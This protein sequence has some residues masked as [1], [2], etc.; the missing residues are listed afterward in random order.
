MMRRGW[1]WLK[2]LAAPGSLRYQLL[3]RSLGIMAVLLLCIGVSQY[4]FMKS[5]LFNN[6]AET[7]QVQ[8]NSVPRD[9]LGIDQPE[10]R[11]R[12][13]PGILR[14]NLG[15]PGDL[16]R[17]PGGGAMGNNGKGTQAPDTPPS[18]TGQSITDSSASEGTAGDERGRKPYFF[19]ADSSLAIVDENGNVT[20]IA[21]D[22]GQP[23]PVISKEKYASIMAELSAKT[24]TKTKYLVV[25]GAEGTGEQLVV[26]R[27]MGMP[28]RPGGGLIQ[29]ST[30]TA[31]L[32]DTLWQQ[33]MI[34]VVL[35]ALA[36]CVGIGL[37]LPVLRRTLVP[38]SRIVSAVQQTDAGN[39]N[40]R[41]PV[42]QG[43]E[44]I[45]R[46]SDSFN[47]MLE[48]L[49]DSFQ[50]EREA[51]E[52]MRRFI[53]DASHELRTPLTSIHG[54]LEVLLR[55]A[56]NRPEQLKS[57]LTSMYGESKRINKLVEDLLLLAKLDRAP[58]LSFRETM[59]DEVLAEMEPQLQ[60]LAGKRSIHI[61][62]QSGLKG[63]YDP[64]KI[65]Q[66]ILNLFHNAVTHTE[67][68]S[69]RI[70]VKLAARD[71]KAE[72]IVNDNGAGIPEEHVP[73]VFDR[74]YRSESS[75]TRSSGGAGLGLSITKSL[76][77]AHGGS[78]EVES[79]VG[80]GTSFIIRLP[81]AQ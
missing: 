67:A 42:G 65:K 25:P 4:W 2:R 1:D 13:E 27:S 51:K 77:E 79:Q 81:L 45:D 17:E 22:G 76:V 74:F 31:P 49:D 60:M 62:I 64:D 44:E 58:Q 57:A 75:R 63:H 14:P 39:L 43:Q 73:H 32:D 78:I 53:A 30:A 12:Q 28:E 21:E 26:F 10:R 56:M 40:E 7:M 38:L 70:S 46:L 80:E 59:L 41:L 55:G 9:L 3:I 6:K 61:S 69:G 24:A 5:F 71:G 52:Q 16:W 66:V 18:V 11:E 36:L 19:L 54:F 33:L 20:N 23:V 29:M 35:S 50:A 72:L 68:G 48:R 47:G 8:I 34:F 15:N 37:Y